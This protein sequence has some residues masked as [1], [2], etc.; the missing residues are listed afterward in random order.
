MKEISQLKAKEAVT[1]L[2]L[3][4][5]FISLFLFFNAFVGMVYQT[6]PCPPRRLLSQPKIALWPRPE[7][8]SEIEITMRRRERGKKKSAKN[9]KEVK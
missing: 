1:F 5:I 6:D 3:L 4:F 9:K 7:G 2:R 8:R